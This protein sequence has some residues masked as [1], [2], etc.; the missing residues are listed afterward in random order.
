MAPRK[1]RVGSSDLPENE[2]P[3][4]TERRFLQSVYKYI[5]ENNREYPNTTWLTKKLF[6]GTSGVSNIKK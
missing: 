2:L 3:T 5:L 1:N 6:V 4:A